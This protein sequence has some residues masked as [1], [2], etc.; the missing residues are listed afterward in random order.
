M[1]WSNVVRQ[2]GSA[3]KT[4]LIV[5]GV[6]GVF[7]AIVVAGALFGWNR[8]SEEVASG[9]ESGFLEG[10]LSNEN[11]PH[12]DATIARHQSLIDNIEQ[13]V[14]SEGGKFQIAAKLEELG[15][16]DD[17]LYLAWTNKGENMMSEEVTEI[18]R[19]GGDW[20]GV[21]TTVINGDG[22]GTVST[23]SG[24]QNVIVIKRPIDNRDFADEWV[25][26]MIDHGLAEPSPA[27]SQ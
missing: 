3:L 24:K 19:R 9:E 15:A 6:I 18:I 21:S 12:I 10:F 11:Q 22:H 16:P 13:I 4:T 17:I 2:R 23:E 20:S 25:M 1:Y 8:V 14:A 27:Q 26:Y 7:I 5:L